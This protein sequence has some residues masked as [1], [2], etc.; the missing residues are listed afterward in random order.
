MKSTKRDPIIT[1]RWSRIG[2]PVL[3]LVIA[4]AVDWLSRTTLSIPN[5]PAI[6]VMAVVFSAFT[7]GLTAGLVSALIA[8]FYFAYFFSIPDQRFHYSAENLARVVIWAFA[9]PAMAVMV[10][11]LKRRSER[12]AMVAREKVVLETELAERRR[13]EAMLRESEAHLQRLNRVLLTVSE[14]NQ[15]IVREHE[16][17]PLLR[18]ACETFLNTRDYTLAWL[19]LMEPDNVTVRLAAVAGPAAP[20]DFSWQ[21]DDPNDGPNCAR[22]A[23]HRAVPVRVEAIL[24]GGMCQTCA[25]RTHAPQCSAVALPLMRGQRRFGVLVVHASTANVFDAAEI[26]LLQELADN[27]THALES[28]E[29]DQQRRTH[30]LHLALLNDLTQAALEAPNLSAMLQLLADRLHQ[31][32]N[33]DSC[34]ITLWDEAKQQPIPAAASGPL[35]DTYPTLRPL[36]GEVTITETVLRAGR[37]VVADDV[38]TSPHVNQK[39]VARVPVHSGIGLPLI[40]SGQ[41]LGAVFITFNQPHHFTE[42]EIVR[43]EQAARQVALAVARMRLL[44]VLAKEK[45]H[46]ELL[47][48]LSQNLAVSLDPGEVATRALELTTTALGV[49]KGELFALD[50]ESDH[51]HLIALSG[52]QSSN[53]E[54]LDQQLGLRIGVGLTGYAAL[55]H[56]PTLAP[57]TTQDEHWLAVPEMD[58][59]VRSAAALP[60]LAG[61]EL[62]G[63]FTLLSERKDFFSL[64]EVPFLN[65]IATPVAL[66]LRN[67]RLF[68]QTRQR[69]NEL[70]I[71]LDMTQAVSSG[72]NLNAILGQ[73]AERLTEALKAT[74]GYVIGVEH[75]TASLIVLA[76]YWADA[77]TLMERRSNLGQHYALRDYPTTVRAITEQRIIVLHT[78]DVAISETERQQLMEYQVQSALLIPLV[79]RG[80]VVGQAEIWESRRRRLFTLAEEQLVQALA[81]QAAVALENARLFAETSDALARERN[82]NAVAQAIS[83]SLDLSTIL[84]T[85]VRL[86]VELVRAES[87]ALSLLARDGQ[88][89]ATFF[90]F[91]LPENVGLERPLPRG[92]GISWH[93]IDTG[94]SLLLADYSAHPQ[95]LP[96]WVA[97]GIHGFMGVPVVAGETRLGILS[98]YLLDPAQQFT[99]RDLAL[100][101]AVAQQAGMAIQ[102]AWLFEAER[103]R[104]KELEI[105]SEASSA[106]RQ[107]QSRTAMLPL[108]AQKTRDLLQA[109]GAVLLLLQTLAEQETLIVAAVSGVGEALLG[110]PHLPEADPLW[111]TVRNGEPLF[112]S[113]VDEQGD[114]QQSAIYRELMQGMKACACIPLKTA[115]ATIGLLHLTMRSAR[116]P[117][118]TERRVLS[119]IAEIAGSALHRAGLMETLEQRVAERTAELTAANARLRELDQLKDDF[120][121]NVSHDLRTP[122]TNIT[123]YLNLLKKRGV[124]ELPRSLPILQRETKRLTGLI[125]DLLS[126]SRLEQGRAPFTPEPHLLDS[127][128][129]EVLQVHS[130]Q[131]EA[132]NLQVL[133]ELR[134]DVPAVR[135]DYPQ[136]MQ[137]LTNL[138]GNAVAYTPRDGQVVCGTTRV[139]AAQV[140]ITISNTGPAI[141]AADLPHLFE[142]FYRGQ[143]G[144]QSGEVGT[145]LGLAICK[146]IVNRHGGR[147]EV[148]SVEGRGTTFHVWLPVA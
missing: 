7:G 62:V 95:A 90:L 23:L 14:I 79:V 128:L 5:P 94:Q 102:N 48:T 145:G 140:V 81:N 52:L 135:V 100:A 138:I 147:I 74:S 88:S 108:L 75:D 64:T 21:L 56:A 103:Q 26:R 82:L 41:K 120:L 80:Q 97:A 66:A 127:L 114:L 29:A 116:V 87:G 65:A 125:E 146:E 89:I 77:A 84:Q 91:N 51:L 93:V 8:W 19:G 20:T 39:I 109:D 85:V 130:V 144:Y 132:K 110:R 139:E 24:A 122:L 54:A 53:I 111:L 40:A 3:T 92:Q 33:A 30:E 47:Y 70:A 45:N 15:L 63:V 38:L 72:L 126:L 76:E 136:M 121:A 4:L 50:P 98:V 28:L 12:L 107:I 1:N 104:V 129:A 22:A 10:G 25:L 37:A 13:T 57:D 101:E 69:E 86:A 115:E 68:A 78:D 43:C 73:V 36:P 83:S 119:A 99:Y 31:L 137:V 60:L 18:A 123:L 49:F 46:L 141:P 124:D 131:A 42:E 17:E 142:R 133:H 148:D 58:D 6:L 71:L 113:D 16:Q 143:T 112:V 27:L 118:L 67:A 2:G 134:P 61:D 44:E 59:W 55:T 34:F 32:L 9:T 117:T 35:R 11:I 106:L 96:A 105:I